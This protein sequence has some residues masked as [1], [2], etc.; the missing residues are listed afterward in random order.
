MA[1]RTLGEIRKDITLDTTSD[2]RRILQM[3]AN[4]CDQNPDAV[5]AAFGAYLKRGDDT[6]QSRMVA[7]YADNAK[8]LAELF[9]VR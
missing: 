1:G 9:E 6:S 3:F 5:K 2:V 4:I 8:Y 7:F